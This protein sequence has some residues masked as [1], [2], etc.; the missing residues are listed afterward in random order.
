MEITN[1]SKSNK[2]SSKIISTVEEFRIDKSEEY[3]SNIESSVSVSS[4]LL[5]ESTDFVSCDSEKLVEKREQSFVDS[6][7]STKSQQ[8][9]TDV[10]Q[11]SEDRLSEPLNIKM[12]EKRELKMEHIKEETITKEQCISMIEKH[13]V[14]KEIKMQEVSG[15]KAFLVEEKYKIEKPS[16][17]FIINDKED[18][19]KRYIT[20]VEV[21]SEPPVSELKIEASTYSM[22]EVEPQNIVI[23]RKGSIKCSPDN[24]RRYSIIEEAPVEM[25]IQRRPS[26]KQ[27]ELEKHFNIAGQKPVEVFIKS[28][29]S[30][31]GDVFQESIE[32]V[33]AEG[34]YKETKKLIKRESVETL[35]VSESLKLQKPNKQCEK[36]IETV[37]IEGKIEKKGDV[38]ENCLKDS[39]EGMEILD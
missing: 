15:I 28:K 26:I 6:I 5:Q 10:F 21:A 4:K 14:T 13:N 18:N 8:S 30:T 33:F 9:K 12:E 32:D 17:T 39:S 34:I 24:R 35:D 38:Q 2:E 16:E 1:L 20:E 27:T 36:R 29:E 37:Y 25:V 19:I 31:S 22:T 23:P 11:R 7:E 3:K